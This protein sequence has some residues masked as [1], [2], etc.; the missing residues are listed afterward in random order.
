MKRYLFLGLVAVI[1]AVGLILVKDL[2]Q[3]PEAKDQAVIDLCWKE[4]GDTT[5]QPA[6]QRVDD[7][8]CRGLEDLYRLNYGSS[9]RAASKQV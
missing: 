9:P 5:I 3:S 4:S 2:L 8:T 1:A 7:A 6:Q